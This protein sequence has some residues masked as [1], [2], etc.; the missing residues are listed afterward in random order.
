MKK[1][2]AIIIMTL[3]VS[4]SHVQILEFP[5]NYENRTISFKNYYFQLPEVD[6]WYIFNIDNNSQSIVIA[7]PNINDVDAS[8]I[9]HQNKK[10][11]CLSKT[12]LNHP[13]FAKYFNSYI[14]VFFTEIP[15][16]WNDLEDEKIRYNYL[17][18]DL[19]YNFENKIIK[20]DT[21][22]N[23]GTLSFENGNHYS[24]IILD[25]V[26]DFKE[27]IVSCSVIKDQTKKYL[28]ISKLWS[29]SKDA[30]RDYYAAL[31]QNI[32]N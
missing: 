2:V 32:N 7:N 22:V 23:I 17:Q 4:C 15:P 10:I 29:K 27:L 9:S 30:H 13:D 31:L 18:E 19:N 16:Q 14:E 21:T 6:N 3:M 24:T 28:L 5:N 1:L 25:T 26:I 20:S 8:V 11:L 12:S